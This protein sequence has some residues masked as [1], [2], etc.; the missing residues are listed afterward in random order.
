M[1]SPY[2]LLCVTTVLKM[3]AVEIESAEY[4]LYLGHSNEI[5]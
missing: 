5:L 4:V 1:M 2:A 3:A